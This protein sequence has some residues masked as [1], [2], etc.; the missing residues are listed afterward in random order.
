MDVSVNS[1]RYFNLNNARD[2]IRLFHSAV[3]VVLVCGPNIVCGDELTENALQKIT[4]LNAVIAGAEAAGIDALKEK[5]TV[6]T[7]E[8]F[9]EYADWDEANLSVNVDYFKRVAKYKTTALETAKELPDFERQEVIVMLDEATAYL[10]QLIAGMATRKPTPNV[11]WSKVSHDG[12][13]LIFDGRP[14]FLTDWTWKPDTRE[15][16]EFHGQQD[17]FFLMHRY[18]L[19]KNGTIAP[20]ILHELKSKPD[21]S[22]GFI[23]LNHKNTPAWVKAE[24]GAEFVMRDDTYTAYDIDHPGA[25]ELNRLLLS[26][27]VP[28]MA[29]KKYTQLGYMLCNEPHFFT[30]KDAWA[31]G[32]VSEHTIKK[33]RIWLKAQ[34][35]STDRLNKLW[36]T[37]FVSFDDV[38]ITIPISGDLQGS[39]RWFDWVSFNMD[40]V[41]DWYQFLKTEIRK[42]DPQAKVHLKIMPNLW[43]N[44]VRN[45][46]IDLEK[47]TR[48]SEIIGNDAGAKYNS[49]WGKSDWQKHYAF[50]WREMSMAHDFFKSVSPEK[51][52]YNTELHFLST[53]KSRDLKMDPMYARATFWLAHTQGLTASQNWYWARQKDLTIKGGAGPGYGGSS[54]QQPRIVNEVHSTCMDLNSYSEEIMAMQR[55]RKPIRIF[56]SKASAINKPKHMDDVF[57]LYESLS[58]EGIPLGFVTR[59]ILSDEDPKNWDVVL[60]HKTQFVTPADQK[61]LREYVNRGGS[62][63]VDDVSLKL[64]Q[65]GRP[66]QTLDG[67]GRVLET[68]SLDEMKSKTL[69][70]IAH[71]GSMPSITVEETNSGDS[72]GC[73]WKCIERENGNQVLSIV[74]V[75]KT[76]A[77]LRVTLKN[78]KLGTACTNILTG[79]AIANTL[80]LE[81]YGVLFVEVSDQ[82]SR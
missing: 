39:P 47:L 14:V 44:N 12:D 62:V 65:Y 22:L 4:E 61:A 56:Y 30:T 57:E 35:Q 2:F 80:K 50:E 71:K 17:G 72:K 8:I 41:T 38:A 45:H 53:V 63:I 40:R 36:E 58:F 81:P 11:D 34:H 66:T 74:N 82:Q 3:L 73:T 67:S 75:G 28:Q 10:K 55:Q 52:M 33:F 76:Q 59:D 9:L 78:A 27:T 13:Q 24:Y 64:D 49:M 20:K 60:V 48:M 31:T 69:R 77:T 15:L 32:P 51:I 18:V 16:T 37:E 19:D 5:M 26:G 21:G 79:Q 1:R 42:H 29:G 54:N 43:T 25:R 46:G 68:T 7:A 23:F 6:R 70:Y